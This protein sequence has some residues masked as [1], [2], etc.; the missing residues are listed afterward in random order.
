LQPWFCLIA[1]Q[2]PVQKKQVSVDLIFCYFFIKKKVKE[3]PRQL[4]GPKH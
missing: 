4:S 1:G 2:K 3:T